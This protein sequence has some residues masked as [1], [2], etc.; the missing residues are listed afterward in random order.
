MP[1]LARFI[2]PPEIHPPRGYTHVV[3]TGPGRTVYI[4]GQVAVDKDGNL[5]GVNDMA[6]QAAQVFKNLQSALSAV[7]A[8]FENVV[9]LTV[10]VT[11]ISQLAAVREVRDRYVNT[12][13][14][15]A[16]TALQVVS[17]ARP[18]FLVEVE[19]VAWLPPG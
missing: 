8:S 7:G 2:N 3:E 4:A 1:D 19:A 18:E 5:V 17:L 10:F 15:P 11:D 16:S 9:K 12:S 6:A 13:S 14:P